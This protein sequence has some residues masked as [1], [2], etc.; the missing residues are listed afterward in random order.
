MEIQQIT[1]RDTWHTAIQ[2]LPY[3]HILQSWDWGEF[4]HRTTG[5]QPERLLFLQS[6]EVLAAASVLTR[7]F[8]PFALMYTPK[9]PLFRDLSVDTVNPVLNTL[10]KRARRAIWLKID[11]DVPIATGLPPEAEPDEDQPHIVDNTGQNFQALL[12]KRGWRFSDDQVQFRNT[13]TLD[14]SQSEDALL[15]GMN[16][17]TRRKIRQSEKRDVTVRETTDE[18]DLHVLYKIYAETGERQEFIIRPWD[19]YRDLWVDFMRGG[20]ATVFVAE[21]GEQILSG[22]V[23]FHFGNRAWY[24][25]GMSS[26]EERDR[27]PNFAVQWEAIRWAK[28]QGY[29]IYDWWG[30]PNEFVETDPMWGVYRF[31]RGFGSTIIRTP[32]AWDYA[33]WPPL[34][35]GYTQAA[36]RFIT[37]LRRR[38]NR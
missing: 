6:S 20:L 30:A 28:A 34:Y 31:K 27:Q 7:R 13:L 17:S 29:T 36:P 22:A 25:Y 8:G 33:P 24:F 37:W 9:G 1:N 12:Q 11:P 10:Q 16:Q 32:G 19:Y 38:R 4:K 14:L 2:T 5:W 35:Y 15:A 21:Y 26:N 23:I 3:A 18:S